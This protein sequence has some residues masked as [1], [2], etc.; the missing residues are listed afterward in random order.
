MR[1][2]TTKPR[3]RRCAPLFMNWL[4]LVCELCCGD[5]SCCVKMQVSSRVTV[6][7]SASELDEQ[8]CWIGEAE[9]FT[10]ILLWQRVCELLQSTIIAF[11]MAIEVL[12][13][14]TCKS[15]VGR[16]EMQD[17]EEPGKSTVQWSKP[18]LQLVLIVLLQVILTNGMLFGTGSVPHS[19]LIL[20]ATPTG[21]PAWR[22]HRIAGTADGSQ[23]LAAI[24][25][26][27]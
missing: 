8:S 6:T 5:C 4:L 3:P 14:R 15:W 18:C 11:A 24:F 27:V 7:A 25:H 22:A 1:I 9:T 23:K 19:D 21:M 26:G 10:C 17:R 2:K 20:R 13:F 12:A 16:R